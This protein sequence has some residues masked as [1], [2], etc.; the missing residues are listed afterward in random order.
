MI[1]S[2]M[3]N[4]D[5]KSCG[6]LRAERMTTTGGLVGQKFGHWTVIAP[7]DPYINGA[8]RYLCRCSCGTEKI[9]VAS[10]LIRGLSKSCG[11]RGK[12]RT[13][14]RIP[15]QKENS[16]EISAETSVKK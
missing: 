10:N 12:D 16:A 4:G 1:G 13:Q 5:S 6:C 8:K 9:V 2:K 7:A 3:K 14:P 11:C 15:N